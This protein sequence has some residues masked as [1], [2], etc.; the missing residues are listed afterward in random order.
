MADGVAMACCNDSEI[1]GMLLVDCPKTM[2]HVEL[3]PKVRRLNIPNAAT[4]RF[5]GAHSLANLSS[6]TMLEVSRSG[7]QLM[8]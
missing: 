8:Q 3:S 6:D 5:S 4:S 7:L 2:R 1:V